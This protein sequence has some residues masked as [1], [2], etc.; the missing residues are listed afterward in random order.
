MINLLVIKL[1][2]V[3][4]DSEEVLECLFMVLVIYCEKYECLLV[5]MYGGGC[6]VDD[7][8]KKFVLLV[9]KKNGLCVMLVD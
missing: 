1:G 5:I 7:L 8:M 6:L 3:L 4:F 2:G 9:V